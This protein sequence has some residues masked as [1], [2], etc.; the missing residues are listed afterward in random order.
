MFIGAFRSNKFFA[1]LCVACIFLQQI[2][3]TEIGGTPSYAA[4][5]ALQG[6]VEQKPM[7]DTSLTATSFQLGVE[8]KEFIKAIKKKK[9]ILHAQDSLG[10]LRSGTREFKLQTHDDSIELRLQQAKAD[11]AAQQAKAQSLKAKI[12]TNSGTMHASANTGNIDLK[13]QSAKTADAL[14]SGVANRHGNALQGHADQNALRTTADQNALQGRTEQN[15]LHALQGRADQSA[16]QGRADQNQSTLR[17]QRE[18]LRAQTS[19]SANNLQTNIKTGA[20]P[21]R[22]RVQEPPASPLNTLEHV[23]VPFHLDLRKLTEDIA[24]DIITRMES[25]LEEARMTTADRVAQQEKL[26]TP[27]LQAQPPHRDFPTVP[28]KTN[29]TIAIASAI[30]KELTQSKQQLKQSTSKAAEKLKAAL[31]AGGMGGS[32]RPGSGA[33]FIIP[34]NAP[35]PKFPDINQS[36]NS[37]STSE[38]ERQLD[39]ELATATTRKGSLAALDA[40]L[41]TAQNNAKRKVAS[42]EPGLD[43]ILTHARTAPQSGNPRVPETAL[44]GDLTEV[45]QWDEWHSRFA[46]LA[47]SPLLAKVAKAKNA[48]GDNSIEIT[49]SRDH[50]LQAKIVRASNQSFDNATVEAYT[51]LSGNPQLQFPPRSKRDSVTFIIDNE[52]RGAGAP[53]AVQSQSGTGDKE[54]VQRTY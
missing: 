45:V 29:M 27:Q 24:P 36:K 11:S 44:N 5:E 2:F 9:P 33:G 8:H 10:L 32:G 42:V 35:A 34:S 16:L 50:R 51:S 15:A 13:S 41:K 6:L 49:V 54:I 37:I 23:R 14:Q 18:Q 28:P 3:I 38:T 25:E 17:E 48:S 26:M 43:M 39:H 20:T 21:L 19:A 40:T 4:R 7:F 31:A 1:K 47:K 53:S 22:A 30:Q 52:H 46:Q 12:E